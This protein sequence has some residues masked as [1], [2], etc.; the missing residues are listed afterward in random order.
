[1]TVSSPSRE[2]FEEVT[3]HPSGC[4]VPSWNGQPEEC[5]R[6]M[7]LETSASPRPGSHGEGGLRVQL[8]ALIPGGD[9][10]SL[11]SRPLN[12]C[13]TATESPNFLGGNVHDNTLQSARCGSASRSYVCFV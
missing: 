2:V 10:S 4:R 11:M 13:A 5:E 9:R 3:G 7:G 6:G 12:S 1:M 8:G